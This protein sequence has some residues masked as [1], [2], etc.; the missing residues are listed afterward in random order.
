V[1]SRCLQFNLKK[2]TLAQI[3][4]QLKMICA[5]EGVA[6]DE[7]GLKI[8]AKA[9]DGSMR[10]ALS[11][12]D[13]SIAFG[14]GEIKLE[15]ISAML[16]SIDRGHVMRLIEA[17]VREDGAALIGEV[18]QLDQQAPNYGAVLD[19]L[20]GA[21]QQIAVIQLVAERE[22]DEDSKALADMAEQISAEDVQLYYQIALNGRRD[23]AVCRDERMSFE[24]TLLRMLAFRPPSESESEPAGTATT[25]AATPPARTPK[26]AQSKPPPSATPDDNG[27]IDDWRELIQAAE[28]RGAARQ[29]A[30]NC[31]LRSSNSARLNLVLASD[32]SQ[33]NTEQLRARL[34]SALS[35][36]LGRELKITITPGK[37]EHPTPAEER[38]AGENE[39]MRAARE[40]IETD[41]TIKA[42]QSAF[43]AVLEADSIQPT[44]N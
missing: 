19:E 32:K 40:A 18:D 22:L 44:D 1:L 12:L 20:M 36:H 29:L 8:L 3:Q 31:E 33:F 39:R 28:L 24:M 7:S 15:Q 11:L 37:P 17:L 43:D 30:D 6:A 41:P 10:D 13:Q 16:G 2:L 27:A 26:A 34:E 21:L 38:I 9:A 23:L 5:E 4:E 14:D 25:R 42:V 35:G